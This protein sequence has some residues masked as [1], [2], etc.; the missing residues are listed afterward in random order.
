VSFQS[1]KTSYTLC[2]K[3]WTL[4][5]CKLEIE[6][7]LCSVKLVSAQC[8]ES[9][10]CVVTVAGKLQYNAVARLRLSETENWSLWRHQ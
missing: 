3:N 9:L 1:S 4:H 8:Y 10:G 6:I 5:I 2:L 7:R